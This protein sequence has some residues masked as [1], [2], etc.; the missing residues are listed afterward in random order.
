MLCTVW[1]LSLMRQALH[2]GSRD[3][4]QD[5]N[6]VLWDHWIIHLPKRTLKFACF[7]L[8]SSLT[9]QPQNISAYG[10]LPIQRVCHPAHWK[11][12]GKILRPTSFF[13]HQKEIISRINKM[14]NATIDG[15][16][17]R[18]IKVEEVAK[19]RG[20]WPE[21]GHWRGLSPTYEAG[22]TLK[23]KGQIQVMKN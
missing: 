15:R 10:S 23:V 20:H 7:L 1:N 13:E 19:Y 14:V 18:Q 2:A 21:A 11:S 12:E 8:S 6:N 3:R 9:L 22:S 4:R 5:K 16:S 17:E